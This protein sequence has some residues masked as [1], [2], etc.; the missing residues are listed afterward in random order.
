MDTIRIDLRTLMI[1]LAI[2]Y[3]TNALLL[4][5]Y[6]S[7][8]M[9]RSLAWYMSSQILLAFSFAAFA[10]YDLSPRSPQ[11][12]NTLTMI[13]GGA[14]SLVGMACYV[15]SQL[16]ILGPLKKSGLRGMWLYTGTAILALFTLAILRVGN[17]MR[18]M[19]F[20]AIIGIPLLYVSWRY[21]KSESRSGLRSLLGW[22]SF[23]AGASFFGRF[24]VAFSDLPYSGFLTPAPSEIAFYLVQYLFMILAGIGMILFFKE[25]DDLHLYEAATRDSLTGVLNRGSFDDQATR[26]ISLCC[27]NGL[28]FSLLIF[29]LDDLKKFNDT[30]GHHAGDAALKD[31]ARRIVATTGDGDLVGRYGGDEFVVLLQTADSA[32][33][34]ALRSC[35]SGEVLLADGRLL[36]YRASGG[37]VVLDG[38]CGGSPSL[39][40]LRIA[41]DRA[42]Y[43]SKAS[44]RGLLTVHDR[45]KA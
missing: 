13:A 20:S 37:A 38:A 25:Q 18:V 42:L 36:P 9:E 3:A 10:L 4:W 32:A 28:P 19:V 34:E 35:L 24:A 17:M 15:F 5:S 39:D 27:R 23:I 7:R 31:F 40:E 14:L 1:M 11:W 33:I 45:Q 41:C 8:R 43:S 6:R 16:L 12:Q 2:G 29:D 30:M 44:G 22:M 21:L 26:A